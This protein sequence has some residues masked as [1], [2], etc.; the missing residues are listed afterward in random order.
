LNGGKLKA[1]TL[2]PRK[3]CLVSPSLFSIALEVLTKA[4]AQLK[5]SSKDINLK[6]KSQR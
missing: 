3:G 4:I 6:E 5:K 2:K 1:I